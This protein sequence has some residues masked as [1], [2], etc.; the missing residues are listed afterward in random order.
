[1]IMN[2]RIRTSK[3]VFYTIPDLAIAG[4]NTTIEGNTKTLA[5]IE[6]KDI[7][8][9]VHF[10]IISKVPLLYVTWVGQIGVKPKTNWWIFK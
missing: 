6:L 8:F 1:M 10:H 4:N 3:G 2:G 9:H 5:D 7:N